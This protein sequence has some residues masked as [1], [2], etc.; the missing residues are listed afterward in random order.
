M[1]EEG[2]MAHIE[3][4]RDVIGLIE[5]EV[6]CAVGDAEGDNGEYFD[7]DRDNSDYQGGRSKEQVNFTENDNDYSPSELEFGDIEGWNTDIDLEGYFA[8]HGAAK[9]YRDAER[10]GDRDAPKTYAGA[11]LARKSQGENVRAIQRFGGNFGNIKISSI[12]PGRKDPERMGVG[13]SQRKGMPE[14]RKRAAATWL[15]ITNDE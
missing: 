8:N 5:E 11:N 3:H 9:E 10:A 4:F 12:V 15:A 14:F 2:E 6:N 13:I 1:T 7:E